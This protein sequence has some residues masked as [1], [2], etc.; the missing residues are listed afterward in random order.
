[1]VRSRNWHR[2][3]NYSASFFISLTLLAFCPIHIFPPGP[4]PRP[5][6]LLDLFPTPYLFITYL[7]YPFE[8][9][10]SWVISPIS[11]PFI[12]TVSIMILLLTLGPYHQPEI[13]FPPLPRCGSTH[14]PASPWQDHQFRITS[15]FS[16]RDHCPCVCGC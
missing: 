15:Q 11:T 12:T 2:S 14:D 4:R 6:L 8:A 5:P 9:R 10:H 7:L 16:R 13:H 1:M 3:N